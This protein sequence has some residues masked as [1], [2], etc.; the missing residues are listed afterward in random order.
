MT[1]ND[2]AQMTDASDTELTTLANDCR[3]EAGSDIVLAADLMIERLQR[4]EPLY[5]RL[6]DP[7]TRNACLDWLKRSYSD[8]QESGGPVPRAAPVDREA[9][10]RARA[11]ATRLSME[12]LRPRR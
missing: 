6:H 1:M 2:S 10:V 12:A 9:R 11:E 3:R 7:L 5:R 4:N 8:A